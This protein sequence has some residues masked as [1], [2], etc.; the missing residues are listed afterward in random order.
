MTPLGNSPEK[1]KPSDNLPLS[2]GDNKV[3][4]NDFRG[5]SDM[6]VVTV[7]EGAVV[8]NIFQTRIH[9]GALVISIPFL[10]GLVIVAAVLAFAAW[11]YFVPATM[12]LGTTNIAIAQFDQKD[13]QGN[14]QNSAL[15][16]DLSAWLFGKLKEEKAALPEGEELTLWHDSA[17]FLEKRGT[18][19]AIHT[20]KE[21]AEAAERL[22]ADVIIYGTLEANQDPARFAPQFYVRN[23]EKKSEADELVGSEQLGKALPVPNPIKN[24][25]EFLDSNLKPRTRALVWLARGIGTD[26]NGEYDKAYQI[27]CQAEAALTDWQRDQGKEVLYY[28]KGREALFLGRSDREANKTQALDPTRWGTCKPFGSQVEA[29]DAAQAAFN[30]AISIN[31]NYARS[32]FGLGQTYFQRANRLVLSNDIPRYLVSISGLPAQTDRLFKLFAPARG[33]AAYRPIALAA[34]SSNLARAV[35]QFQYAAS[36]LPRDTPAPSRLDIKNG[37]AWANAYNLWGQAYLQVNDLMDAEASFKRAIQI[38]EPLIARLGDSDARL[39]A[40]T[41]LSLGAAQRLLAHA[42]LLQNRRDESKAALDDAKK[43]LDACIVAAKRQDAQFDSFTQTTVLPG[44][45]QLQDQV[46]QARQ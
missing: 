35:A 15:A 19:G 22:N 3:V 7:G 9:I 5:A 2:T 45:L 11:L 40:Q 26:L 12:P 16:S 34:A 21:A 33:L 44:C 31:R 37:G 36:L 43:A 29:T 23:R 24:N 27:F 28:M 20:E 10:I 18:I 32:Y 4:T 41:N 13:A 25:P 39:Q 38:L 6:N 1:Q 46:T 8:G 42:L 14:V 30:E 17:T